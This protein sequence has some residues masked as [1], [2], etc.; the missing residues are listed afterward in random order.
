MPTDTTPASRALAK[1][2]AMGTGCAVWSA[3]TVDALLA[4][5]RAAVVRAEAWA[6]YQS[7]PA[8]APLRVTAAYDRWC[9][10]DDAFDAATDALIAALAGE[11]DDG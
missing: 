7:L 5:A 2:A 6:E 10:L 4:L 9:D 1:L 3:E 8:S 11:V